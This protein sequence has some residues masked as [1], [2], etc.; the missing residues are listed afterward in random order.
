[1]LRPGDW[2]IIEFGHNDGGSPYPASTDNGRA[3]CP[4]SGLLSAPSSFLSAKLPTKE[5]KHA[6]RSMS[7]CYSSNTGV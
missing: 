4:G 2:V 5:T 1:M 7:E 3:D 6:R